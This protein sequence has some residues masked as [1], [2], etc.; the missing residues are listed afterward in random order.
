MHNIK[1]RIFGKKNAR[2]LQLPVS[3]S[4]PVYPS[5]HM[6]LKKLYVVKKSLHCPP[7]WQGDE[8]QTSISKVF[9]YKKFPSIA[10]YKKP[11][12]V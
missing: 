4:A 2:H 5:A 8:S 1:L 10:I 7:F 9:S 11:T 12:N 3:Q 6:Q